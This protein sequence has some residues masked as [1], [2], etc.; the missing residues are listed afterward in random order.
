[1]GVSQA[2]PSPGWGPLP[3][4]SHMTG[5]GRRTCWPSFP[6]HQ[7]QTAPL[8]CCCHMHMQEGAH[9]HGGTAHVECGHGPCHWHAVLHVA[10][11]QLLTSARRTSTMHAMPIV[12]GNDT[13]IRDPGATFRRNA[14]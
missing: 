8:T 10:H 7:A 5:N 6:P 2:V 1:M 3:E 13:P 12:R 14:L 11:P 4:V 9:G